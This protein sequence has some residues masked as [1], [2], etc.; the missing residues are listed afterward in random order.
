MPQK[1]KTPA[2]VAAEALARLRAMADTRKSALKFRDISR[3][4]SARFGVASPR[5]AAWPGNC[6]M[7]SK[8]NGPSR[9]PSPLP[10][11]CSSGR[12]LRPRAWPP[13]SCCATKRIFPWSFSRR[14]AAGWNRTFW[15][16]G[17]RSTPSARRPWGHFWRRLPG[18]A[19]RDRNM[20]RAIPTAGCNGLRSSPF[21]SWLKKKSTWTLPIAWRPGIS[22]PMTTWCRRPL[23]GS[24]ARP[25]KRDMRRLEKFLLAHGPSMPRT[26][27]RYAIE[28]F[29]ERRRSELLRLTR[30]KMA[31]RPPRA[32][33][34]QTS[35]S[36]RNSTRAC[37]QLDTDRR[38]ACCDTCC[39]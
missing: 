7:R 2:V 6:T 10:T 33:P 38:R 17:P 29:P 39:Q 30:A 27:L 24:C 16:T 35:R 36:D 8:R 12:N 13:W 9:T 15:T 1:A 22:L 11:F 5:S 32:I 21:S 26:T 20:G 23:A 28:R 19:G 34:R 14:R 3:I 18:A 4:R 25:G 37:D 31:D